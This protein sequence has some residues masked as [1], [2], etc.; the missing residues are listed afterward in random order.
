MHGPF[1]R[2]DEETRIRDEGIYCPKFY[3][4]WLPAKKCPGF[5]KERVVVVIPGTSAWMPNA[6]HKRNP[7][8]VLPLA[9]FPHSFF[10]FDDLGI[11]HNQP[12]E[13]I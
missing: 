12:I 5:F 6:Q 9:L 4:P 13:S 7:F 11:R 3:F 8:F 2:E 10:L 1:E